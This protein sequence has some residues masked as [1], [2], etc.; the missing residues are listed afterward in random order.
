MELIIEKARVSQ[1]EEVL[2]CIR[3][4]A[5]E[6][7]NLIVTT[8]NLKNYTVTEEKFL[9]DGYRKSKTGLMLVGIVDEK[10]VSLGTLQGNS[11]E[12]KAGHRVTLGVFVLKDYWNM[13]IGRQMITA[14][15]DYC[16]GNPYIEIVD[17]DV[18]ADN[19]AAI[20]LYE[21][22]GFETIGGYRDYFKDGDGSYEDAILMALYL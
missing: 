11:L 8:E 1:A 3:Q 18:R 21:R 6:S 4:A 20:G 9:I 10:I 14:L 16:V 19:Y 5:E 13:G 15:L 17:L 7:N 12:S 2:K 22:F